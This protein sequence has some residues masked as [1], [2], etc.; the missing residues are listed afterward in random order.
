MLKTDTW[1]DKGFETESSTHNPQMLVL[2][3]R[4]LR[5]P[6]LLQGLVFVFHSILLTIDV[7]PR[8]LFFLLMLLKWVLKFWL[9][10]GSNISL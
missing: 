2:R 7:L 1:R 8:N 9:I 6:I 4:T 10:N 3:S 5:A